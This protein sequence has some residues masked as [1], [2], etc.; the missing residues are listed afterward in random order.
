M[1]AT[2]LDVVIVGGGSAGLSA[3]LMLGRSR[4]RV[5]VVDGGTPRNGV[6]GHMHGVLGR[7]HTSPLDLLAAG[8]AELTRYDDV[9][10]VS[11]EVAS[12][13]H[14]DGG[15]LAFEVVL[16][17][18]ER[19]T[20]RRILVTTGLADR[21]PEIPGLAEQW[22][23]GV[24][25]CPYCDGW[26]VRDR[27]IAVIPT[28]AA[29]AHQAQLLRQLS[30]HV[31]FHSAGFVLP[32]AARAAMSARGIEVDERVVAEVVS[33][34]DGALR[35]I[36]YEDGAEREVDAIFI[37]PRPQPNDAVLRDL[38]ARRMRND[39]VDWVLVDDDGRTS[40][41]GVWAAGNVV[42]ARATVPMAMSAGNAAGAALNADLMDED[43]RVAVAAAG[44]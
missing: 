19:R 23:S 31:V 41:P 7:D 22:G 17:S 40:V 8:R 34:D 29:N 20:T 4:R 6:A 35:G 1:H 16:A 27:R 18:G 37:A 26:E 33:G 13:T 15:G 9:A 39:G 3:A 36:R 28:S 30:P 38:G 24:V 25:S 2:D 14:L 11:D 44:G 42:S 32:P 5:L 12:A 10:V 43:I 21:L